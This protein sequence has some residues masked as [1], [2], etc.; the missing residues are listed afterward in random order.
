MHFGLLNLFLNQM[1]N[2]SE[3]YMRLTELLRETD[4]IEF[5]ITPSNT[6][7][8]PDITPQPVLATENP[9]DI[10]SMDV[11]LFI[12]L[13]EW[14]YEDAESDIQLHDIAEKITAISSGK[15]TLS[16]N[17]YTDIISATVRTNKPS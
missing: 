14:A 5:A 7:I 10:I 17:N 1:S 8:Q 2:K 4:E 13:L 15:Q 16:M 11:P 6:N 3:K 9:V 12:R